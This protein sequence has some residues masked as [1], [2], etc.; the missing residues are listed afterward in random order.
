MHAER[1]PPTIPPCITCRI[2]L[3]PENEDAGRIFQIVR[4]QVLTRFNGK[5]DVVVDLN[6]GAVWAA[7]DAYEIKDRTGTFEKVMR[8][9]HQIE[10]ERRANAD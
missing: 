6:H 5:V 8:A 1:N 3:R 4:G 10:A 2:P 7:I 9:F